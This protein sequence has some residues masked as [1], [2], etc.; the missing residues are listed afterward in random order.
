[1]KPNL[2][3]VHLSGALCAHFLRSTLCALTLLACAASA[4]IW[5]TVDDY[6]Y[7]AGQ[8]AENMS[9]AVAP[10]GMLL[11]A[12]WGKAADGLVHALVMASADGGSTWSAPLDDF[13]YAPGDFAYYNTVASDPAGSLYAA[14][15]V[16]DG[17]SFD[18][19]W[20]TRRSTDGG[21]TWSTVDTVIRLG[22]D[23][24]AQGTAADAFGNVYVA[25]YSGVYGWEIRK[26]IGGTNFTTVDSIPA[27]WDGATAIYVHPTSGIFAVGAGAIGATSSKQGRVTTNYGWLVRR[28][29]SGGVTWSSVDS[30]LLSSGRAS[31]A[32]GIG[33]DALGNLYVVGYADAVS[34]NGAKQ[35]VC[36][37]WIV[38]KSVNGGASWSTIDNYQLSSTYGSQASAF[39]ADSKGNLYVVG[40]GSAAGAPQ[41]FFRMGAGGPAPWPP[42]DTFQP[43]PGDGPSAVAAAANSTGNV[44][45]GGSNGSHWLVRKH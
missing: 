12:G 42:V 10:S 3:S 45:V 19:Y 5:Q 44:F 23:C 1:M 43:A 9:L 33:A 6:Q 27:A 21:L 17:V 29:T 36:A 2:S 7:V 4:Q 30:F 14:G 32:S 15:W 38:R 31:G 11:A 40:S 20:F 28:S 22:T 13:M 34:G 18:R 37:H 24:I 35:A 41:W 25:G 26:G 39:V 8:S 16:D